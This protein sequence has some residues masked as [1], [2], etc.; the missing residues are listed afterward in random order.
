[1]R[2]GCAFGSI[3]LVLWITGVSH[4]RYLRRLVDAE[5][6]AVEAFHPDVLFTEVDPGAF[7][8]SRVAGIPI[9][10]TYASVFS[11]GVGSF[12]WRCLRNAEAR[13]LRE[14]GLDAVEPQE[15]IKDRKTLKI[16]PSIPELEEDLPPCDDLSYVG[17]LLH[18]FRTAAET[19]FKPEPG[20][21]YVFVYVG[22]ASIALSK[23]RQKLPL[24]FPAGSETLCL[25]STQGVQQEE[26]IGNVTFRPFW[27]AE[28]LMPHCSW[29]LCHGGHNTIIQALMNGI[30]LLIFPGA[31]FERRFNA[32]MVELA[33]AGHFGELPQFNE[34]WLASAML[35]RDTFAARAL[36]LGE[37][38]KALGGA[39]SAV[40]LIEKMSPT[41]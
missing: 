16:I 34:A 9:A 2:P 28:G 38:I 5:L 39:T 35:D 27:D 4:G 6:A 31:I 18:S 40:H 23:I 13:I 14:H 30:P 33:G 37:K 25:V 36:E 19:P 29:V 11:I 8:V 10:C 7:V 3:W 1:M 21:R 12:P 32:R 26:R 20:K 17:S 24:V 41:A 22:T 15:M